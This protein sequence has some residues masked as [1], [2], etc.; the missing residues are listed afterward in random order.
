LFLSETPRSLGISPQNITHSPGSF[1]KGMQLF[2]FTTPQGLLPAEACLKVT[3]KNFPKKI[4]L[5]ILG[6]ASIFPCGE[7]N[8]PFSLRFPF[9]EGHL[10]KILDNLGPLFDTLGVG[11]AEFLTLGRNPK[12]KLW[13]NEDSPFREPGLLSGCEAG[14]GPGL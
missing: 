11:E 13:C 2:N 8:F 12:A 4:L 9:A 6:G 3:F 14:D 7:G 10:G 5:G 1:L